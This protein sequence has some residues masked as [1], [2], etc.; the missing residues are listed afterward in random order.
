MFGFHSTINLYSAADWLPWS[1]QIG[2][3]QLPFTLQPA[4]AEASRCIDGFSCW[5]RN[6]PALKGPKETLKDPVKNQ[7]RNASIPFCLYSLLWLVSIHPDDF[8]RSYLLSAFGY[9]RRKNKCRWGLDTKVI[10]KR[11]LGKY[12]SK[13]AFQSSI[14]WV[15]SGSH[16]E[17]LLCSSSCSK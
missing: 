4:L 16:S 14:S 8:H 17:V 10:Q 5:L 1:S 12:F 15:S 11:N 13:N 9:P 2:S 3:I 6:L 7:L